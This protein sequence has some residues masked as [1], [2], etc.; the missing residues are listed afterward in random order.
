MTF[1]SICVCFVLCRGPIREQP[2]ISWISL[3]TVASMLSSHSCYSDLEVLWKVLL[4]VIESLWLFFL[5]TWITLKF[6][7][8]MLFLW[9]FSYCIL[10]YQQGEWPYPRWQMDAYYQMNDLKQMNVEHHH[11]HLFL[12]LWIFLTLSLTEVHTMYVSQWTP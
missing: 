1:L 12:F 8:W 4:D 10:W 9:S 7:I 2:G 11:I 5:I 3:Y 6:L